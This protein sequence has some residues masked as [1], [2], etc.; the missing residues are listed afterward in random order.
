[1]AS[2][3]RSTRLHPYGNYLSSILQG[4]DGYLYGTGANGPY[5]GGVV[6]KLGPDETY[7]LLYSFPSAIGYYPGPTLI[8]D[9]FGL[10]YGAIVGGSQPAFSLTTNGLLANIGN[11]PDYY[12]SGIMLGADGNFY[13]AS[14]LGG[15]GGQGSIWAMNR[16]G[17]LAGSSPSMVAT[18]AVPRAPAPYSAATV[19]YM[20]WPRTAVQAEAASFTL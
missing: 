3:A 6:W 17:Q 8:Q 11:V 14:W 5:Q 1:M 15:E 10:L 19:A 12:P 16:N 4:Q 18:M 20:G 2:L 9:N 13:G 7:N